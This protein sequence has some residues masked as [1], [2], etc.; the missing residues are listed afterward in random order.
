MSEEYNKIKKVIEV[1]MVGDAIIES[2]NLEIPYYNEEDYES[3]EQYWDEMCERDYDYSIT[4]QVKVKLIRNG[5]EIYGFDNKDVFDFSI[6][7]SWTWTHGYNSFLRIWNDVEPMYEELFSE[8]EIREFVK[9]CIHKKTCEV[10]SKALENIG[11]PGESDNFSEIISE[12]IW[13]A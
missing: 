13:H 10:A 1:E 3:P 11:N 5:E 8:D 4:G 2:V 7:G 6:D 9:Y 12:W